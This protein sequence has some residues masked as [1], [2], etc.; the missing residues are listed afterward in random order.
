P[1]QPADDQQTVVTAR[2]QG[3]SW[4][5]EV[6]GDIDCTTVEELA[7]AT[8]Q[9]L[10][11]QSGPLVLDLARLR[12][13]DSSL[14]NHLLKTRERRRTILVAVPSQMMRVLELTGTSGV[15]ELHDDLRAALAGVAE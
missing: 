15:F 7:A 6:S 10:R 12:F 5:I 2:R 4:V 3:P 8:E 11:S 9:G 14:L 13:G 1:M